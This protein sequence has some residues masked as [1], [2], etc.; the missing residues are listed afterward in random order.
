MVFIGTKDNTYLEC[1]WGTYDMRPEPGVLIAV[2]G[3]PTLTTFREVKDFL[4][5]VVHFRHFIGSYPHRAISLNTLLR[6]VM[7]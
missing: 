4:G 3:S 5:F 7:R 1:F 6:K 2:A